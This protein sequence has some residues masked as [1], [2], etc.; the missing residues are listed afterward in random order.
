MSVDD[1]ATV[2]QAE[3]MTIR[4]GGQARAAVVGPYGLNMDCCPRSSWVEI[5]E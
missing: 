1:S 3:S 2:D 4:V 5:L